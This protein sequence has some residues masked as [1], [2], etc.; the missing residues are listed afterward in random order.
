MVVFQRVGSTRVDFAVSGGQWLVGGGVLGGP[1]V[2]DEDEIG[3]GGGVKWQQH[4]RGWSVGMGWK[5][6]FIPFFQAK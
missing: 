3:M 1:M 6:F 2:E 5:G 4:Q